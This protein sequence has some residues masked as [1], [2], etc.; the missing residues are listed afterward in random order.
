MKDFEA[1]GLPVGSALPVEMWMPALPGQ[2]PRFVLSTTSIANE[3][4]EISALLLEGKG[5]AD[6]QH[7]DAEET[8]DSM[9]EREDTQLAASGQKRR[10]GPISYSNVAIQRVQYIGPGANRKRSGRGG[11]TKDE[12]A[13]M[14]KLALFFTQNISIRTLCKSSLETAVTAESMRAEYA[15]LANYSAR[16]VAN[17]SHTINATGQISR[18]A[19]TEAIHASLLALDY[20]VNKQKLISRA[21]MVSLH[22]DNSSFNELAMTGLVLELTY[23]HEVGTW[24]GR[25]RTPASHCDKEDDLLQQ[26]CECGQ[27]V[28]RCLRQRRQPDDQGG[29]VQLGALTGNV[30]PSA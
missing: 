18:S 19:M 4:E 12:G 25:S 15:P 16:R 13:L 28:R 10:S 21:D 17:V 3:N 27:E 6:R 9:K 8:E 22:F 2:D 26:F 1:A 7:S 14:G 11:T 29:A 24:K 23:F 30:W 5:K 20:T